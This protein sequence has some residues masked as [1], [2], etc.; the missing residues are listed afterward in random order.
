MITL[1]I[2]DKKIAL[3]VDE[4]L[5]I[6]Q[7]V[8]KDIEGLSFSSKIFKGACLMGNGSIGMI[9]DTEFFFK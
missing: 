6:Q 9:L 4:V 7:V 8:L 3:Y 1:N 5:G 2:N